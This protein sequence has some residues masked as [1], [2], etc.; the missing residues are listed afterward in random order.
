MMPYHDRAK[1]PLHNGRHR[2]NVSMSN[3]GGQILTGADGPY[4]L[5][6]EVMSPFDDSV[7]ILPS[8]VC[9]LL[10]LSSLGNGT[11][12]VGFTA[13]RKLFPSVISHCHRPPDDQGSWAHQ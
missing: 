4:C 5:S 9:R 12:E 7:H 3:R 8:H 10:T 1:H 6:G 2:W 13:T 11:Q